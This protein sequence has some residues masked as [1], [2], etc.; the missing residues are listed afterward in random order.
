ME[1][2]CDTLRESFNSEVTQSIEWRKQQLEALLRLV[3]ENKDEMC[4]ALKKDLNKHEHETIVF[5][6]ALIKNGIIN[7]LNNLDKWVKPEKVTLPVAVR[8]LY[9]TYIQHQPL[10]VVLIISAWNYPFQVALVPL[11]GALAGGNC[12]I[13][14]PSEL[15]PTTASLLERIWPKYFDQKT[16]ALVN[17][18]VKETQEL[19]K[20]RFDHIFYTGST[21]VG[22][23]IMEAASKHMT[24]V[25]LECGGK[26]PVY[27]D[28]S[29]DLSITAKRI[30]WGRFCN[31]GQTCVAPDY[32]LC[33]AETQQKILP[34]LKKY[35]TDFYG[36]NPRESASYG[37][38]INERHFKR[39]QSL[40]DSEK[41]VIGGKS[42]AS[43]LYISPT[44]MF[45]VSGNDKVMQEE[46]FGPILPFVVVKSKDDAIKFINKRDKPLAL[47]V[48]ASKDSIYDDFRNKTTSGS[49]AF[50]EVLMQVAFECVP[51][52]G[53]GGS[54]IGRYHGKYSFETFTHPR[55]ILKSSFFGDFLTF[56]RYPPYSKSNTAKAIM[57]SS[58]RRDNALLKLIFSP[59]FLAAVLVFG[60]LYLK[61]SQLQNL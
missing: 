8:G 32:V 39:V 22:K 18:G 41:V 42:D 61:A 43:D 31:S 53:V 40:I 44:V 27:V 24:P 10:G 35:L 30:L 15:S 49:M 7:T 9:S 60:T 16:V 28:E 51:F 4:E 29:A 55:T 38:I 48:F 47:Y 36:E 50:N 54:G 52:G 25:T 46:I 19:L 45:N 59:Y 13:V 21:A 33:T 12:A 3:D 26:S 20:Q 17:G 6:I 23:V 58:E 1:Q 57:A 11:V 5:E 37:R 34:F 56:F 2:L 14:K